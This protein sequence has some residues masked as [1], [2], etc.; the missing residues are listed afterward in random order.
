MPSLGDKHLVVSTTVIE[1]KNVKALT[2]SLS[3]LNYKKILFGLDFSARSMMDNIGI[4]KT[5]LENRKHKARKVEV[6]R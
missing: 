2:F 5:F 6:L 3:L 4:C 1:A